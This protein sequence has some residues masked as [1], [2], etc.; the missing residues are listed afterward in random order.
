MT[1]MSQYPIS[2]DMMPDIAT[3]YCARVRQAEGRH[4]HPTAGCPHS[5]METTAIYANAGEEYQSIA[6]RM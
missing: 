2:L 1:N 3:E 6:A 4:K 5:Q